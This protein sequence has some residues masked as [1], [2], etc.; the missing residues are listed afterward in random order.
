MIPNNLIYK[1][2]D[3]TLREGYCIKFCM[4]LI[5]VII[6]TVSFIALFVNQYNN[7]LLPLI[8]EF[9]PLSTKVVSNFADKQH[10]VD[11]VRL[12]TEATEFACLYCFLW[13]S[14]SV[15]STA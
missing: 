6:T 4:K 12:Q 1:Y 2:M 14:G 11:I 7:R 9:C 5:A 10:S 3:L 13:I 15:L 8:R